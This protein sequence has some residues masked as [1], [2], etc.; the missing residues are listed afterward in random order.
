VA[1]SSRGDAAVARAAQPRWLGVLDDKRPM[2]LAAGTLEE[3]G[4]VVDHDENLGGRMV[5]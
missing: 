2:Q 3:C 4:I 1:R 5:L